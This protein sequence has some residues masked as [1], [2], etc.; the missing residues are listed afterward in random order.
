MRHASIVTTM[1]VYGTAMPDSKRQANSKIVRM[2][3][4]RPNADPEPEPQKKAG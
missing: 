4:G 2:V 3:L 1:N